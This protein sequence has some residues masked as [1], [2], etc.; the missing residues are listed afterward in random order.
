MCQVCRW[1]LRYIASHG[2]VHPWG[3]PQMRRLLRRRLVRSL[4]KSIYL[5][6]SRREKRCSI[7]AKYRLVYFSN[8]HGYTVV[9]SQ[10]KSMSD[11]AVVG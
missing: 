4:S 1:S 10:S 7:V 9:T 8:S 3:M 2:P 6:A 11:N 5:A